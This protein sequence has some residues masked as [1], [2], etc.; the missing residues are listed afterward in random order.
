[1]WNYLNEILENPERLTWENW[2]A[3][4]ILIGVICLWCLRSKPYA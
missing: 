1:M 2:T 4:G 3:I